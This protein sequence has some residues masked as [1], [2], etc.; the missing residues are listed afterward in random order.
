MWETFHL[1]P[2]ASILDPPR[3]LKAVTVE[4]IVSAAGSNKGASSPLFCKL[5]K[6]EQRPTTTMLVIETK[7]TNV[8]TSGLSPQLRFATATPS[9]LFELRL[10]AGDFS[11]FLYAFGL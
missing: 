11:S 8:I 1:L 2:L 4:G 5:S 6:T 3:R 7:A 10:V 9:V